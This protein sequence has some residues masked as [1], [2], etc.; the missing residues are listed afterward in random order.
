M[1][2][3]ATISRVTGENADD[4]TPF[5]HKNL[6]WGISYIRKAFSVRFNVAYAYKVSG[7]RNAAS[8]TIP[9]GTFSYVAPQI[10]QDLSFEY[11]FMRRFSV[12]GSARNLGGDPKQT[13]R[14][15]PSTPAYTRPQS[16]QNFGTMVTLGLRST[17]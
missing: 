1:F 5:A 12:Y 2:G 3:N 4:F 6:N 8:A 14:S 16:I 17:F 13:Y 11:R 9:D 7:A 10:T 15:G